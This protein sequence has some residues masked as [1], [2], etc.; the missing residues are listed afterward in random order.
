[1]QAIQI[2]DP[3][4]NEDYTLEFPRDVRTR[5]LEHNFWVLAARKINWRPYVDVIDS[6]LK[7]TPTFNE[8]VFG[9]FLPWGPGTR[10]PKVRFREMWREYRE[11]GNGTILCGRGPREPVDCADSMVRGIAT[12]VLGAGVWSLGAVDRFDRLTQLLS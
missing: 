11:F 8:H 4:A 6:L 9:T 7:L 5:T 3:R 2:F 10:D 1:M 12:G